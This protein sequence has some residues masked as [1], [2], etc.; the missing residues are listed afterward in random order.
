MMI[1]REDLYIRD[2]FLLPH[3]GGY[4]LVGTTDPT[5]WEGAGRGFSGYYTDDLE[6][7]EGPYSLF[8][9]DA[10]F[11][12]DENF[13]APEVHL[14]GGKYYMFATFRKAGGSR[15][16]QILVCDRPLG[17]Y[18]PLADPFTPADWMSL[19][20][21]LHVENGVP[22]AVFCR[23]WTQVDDGEMCLVRLSDDLTR[24]ASRPVTLFKASD[25]P[26]VR[27]HAPGKFITDGPFL[28]RQKNSL[29]MLWSSM[30]E[31][32]YAMGLARSQAGVAGPWMHLTDPIYAQNGGH[33]MVFDFDGTPHIALHAPNSPHMSERPVFFPLPEIED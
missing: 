13:W 8:E 22:Y 33:G 19:D 18:A 21:T 32:G 24:A 23:E 6:T 7:F 11:W 5:A 9:P 10:D 3:A 25:A 26:W 31:K 30:G 2:P 29:Y 14:F 1:K 16:C 4:C 28:F 17:R 15:R 20:A 12:A 27:P